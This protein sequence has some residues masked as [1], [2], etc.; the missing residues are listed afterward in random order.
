MF[1]TGSWAS[2]PACL[3]RYSIQEEVLPALHVES[4]KWAGDS[5]SIG[6]G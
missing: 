5:L 2:L 3:Q 6:S 1:E 4:T